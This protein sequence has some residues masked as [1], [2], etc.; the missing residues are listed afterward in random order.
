MDARARNAI[1]STIDSKA[2]APS[3]MDC[4]TA[5]DLWMA[6]QP[7][8]AYTQEEV[9]RALDQV[10]IELCSD[11]MELVERMHGVVNKVAFTLPEERAQYET[12]TVQAALLNLKQ[13]QHKMRF[14]E[15][16]FH[17]S[18]RDTPQTVKEFEGQFLRVINEEKEVE[19]HNR[20]NKSS[21]QAAYN[22]TTKQD[23][24]HK[25]ECDYCHKKGHT[26]NKCFKK[27]R[28]QGGEDSKGKG[29]GKGKG[30]GK[31]KGKGKEGR[32]NRGNG[33]GQ[34]QPAPDQAV[35]FMARV[36]MEAHNSQEES[37]SHPCMQSNSHDGPEY[38]SSSRGEMD[39]VGDGDA[40]NAP[41][42]DQ[43]PLFQPVCT[44]PMFQMMAQD[45]Q[46]EWQSPSYKHSNDFNGTEYGQNEVKMG[47]SGN[48]NEVNARYQDQFCLFQ[49]VGDLPRDN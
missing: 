17:M 29:K 20:H 15:L 10:R 37:Q 43:F 18:N 21:R 32:G 2:F 1:N 12:R 35:S 9:H 19:Q 11:D 39:E 47:K 28:E 33:Q 45:S 42:Q 8:E 34:G 26:E 24:Q 38:D 44:F 14:F 31:G 49:A 27:Q 16:L 46:N 23:G 6:L 48:G 30:N 7:T 4:E 36:P 5:H 3:T 25:S 22:A 40:V 13:P 41:C